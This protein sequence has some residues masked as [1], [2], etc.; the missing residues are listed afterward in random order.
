[1]KHTR[2]WSEI[3]NGL[4]VMHNRKTWSIKFISKSRAKKLAHQRKVESN[5]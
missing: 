2:H 3:L 4:I 5:K 1:M